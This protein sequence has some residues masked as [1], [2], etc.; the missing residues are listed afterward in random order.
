MLNRP[1]DVLFVEADSSA[2]SYQDLSKVFSAIETPTWSLLLAQS[3]RAAGFG[4][5][6]LDGNA[7]RLTETQAISRITCARPRVACF[8]VYGQNPNSGTTNMAGAL[9]LAAALKADSPEILICLVGS[10]VSALPREVLGH[11]AVDFVLLNEGVYALRNLLTALGSTKEVHFGA[12]RGI[13]WKDGPEALLNEPE[14]VVPQD[15]MD[16]D[17]PGYAWDLL[18]YR[19]KPLDLYR[20]H[21]WH[22]EFDHA[23]RTPFAAIYTSLGCRF[24]C[25]FCMINIVNRK[26]NAEGIS[27]ADSRGMRYWSPDFILGEFDKLAALGVETL[28]LSDEMFFLDK[29]YY[30]PLLNGLIERGH[31][32]RMW[33]YS[34][35]DTVRNDFLDLF[36]KAGVGWLALGIEAGNQTVRRE[37]SKGSFQEVN[38]REV[39]RQTRDHGINVIA[40]YIFGFP[41]D[42]LETMGQTLDLALELNTE[43]VNMYPCM[44]LPGSPLYYTAKQ[45]GWKLPE[46][47]AGYGFL[48][49]DSQPL[50]TKTLSAADVLRFRDDAWQRYFTDP[51][52]L[53]LVE[54]KFGQRERQ[55]VVEMSAIRLRRRLLGD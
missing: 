42:T 11:A 30:E 14:R 46:T 15:R 9:R 19:D 20:A 39:V 55:N 23:K 24:A 31:D 53:D 21:F 26:D 13:G 6:I 25:D 34:R 29:R 45:M 3:C 8:V 44:A 16:L 51:G 18:P 4:V 50:P 41:T 49:Y 35:V 36:R 40:N 10:H 22:S 27:S 2:S 47:E 28:R 54:R 52:Y 12:I 1:L 37:V 17:L 38:I 7:E 32:F 43:M 33:S 5:G 48:S